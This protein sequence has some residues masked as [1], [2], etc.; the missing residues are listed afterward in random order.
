MRNIDFIRE[1]THTAAGQWQSV[2]AGLNIDVPSSPLKHTACPACG[3]TDRFRFDDNERG[4]H[5]DYLDNQSNTGKEAADKAAHVVAGWV[6]LPPGEHKADW[7]DHHQQYGLTEATSMFTYSI[8][9][10]QGES[11]KPKSQAIEGG[12]S[13]PPEIDPLKPRIESREDGVYQRKS[14]RID[15]RQI[16]VYVLTFQ[17]EDY[18]ASEE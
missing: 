11:V 1:V 4:A 8:Y 2:L 14:P 6:A 13:S 5:N 15:G 10:I 16:N 17:T 3:G 12:K 7:N 18:A 9:Q